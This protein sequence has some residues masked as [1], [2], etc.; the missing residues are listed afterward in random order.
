VIC[1][2]CPFSLVCLSGAQYQQYCVAC[3]CLIVQI[4]REHGRIELATLMCEP[5]LDGTRPF[6]VREHSQMRFSP[7][8]FCC[9]CYPQNYNFDPSPACRR[10]V[11][12]YVATQAFTH[13]QWR[14]FR[15]GKK[16]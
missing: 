10:E 5:L 4:P 16:A 3:R 11:V 12:H 2:E 14:Y 7:A 8:S 13:K 6:N 9:R 15:R 1:S